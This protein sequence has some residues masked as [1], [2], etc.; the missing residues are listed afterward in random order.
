MRLR[1][2]L[3]CSGGAVLRISPSDLRPRYAW[4]VGCAVRRMCVAGPARLPQ[5]MLCPCSSVMKIV[6]IFAVAFCFE[7]CAWIGGAR[8]LP[9]RV[10]CPFSAA[11]FADASLCKPAPARGA[12]VYAV[13]R[14]M[15]GTRAE[16]RAPPSAPMARVLLAPRKV[17]DCDPGLFPLGLPRPPTSRGRCCDAEHS[18]P[19]PPPE[20]AD[21]LVLCNIACLKPSVGIRVW[22]C[23]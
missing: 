20:Q 12:R 18:A 19:A 13:A 4:G 23:A 16:N 1:C 2:W 17:H 11:G 5:P 6:V 15:P 14:L 10:S 21:A 9:K 8:R 7:S 3:T 22:L